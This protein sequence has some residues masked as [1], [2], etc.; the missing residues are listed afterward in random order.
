VF[1]CQK[2]S[3]RLCTSQENHAAKNYSLKATKRQLQKNLLCNNKNHGRSRVHL[4]TVNII[5]NL[6]FAFETRRQKI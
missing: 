3:K 1:G 4:A 6:N 2:P 5:A